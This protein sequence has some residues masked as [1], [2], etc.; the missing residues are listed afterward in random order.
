M[1]VCWDREVSHRGSCC[2]CKGPE[3]RHRRYQRQKESRLLRAQ[4]KREGDNL[5]LRVSEDQFPSW[6]L[7]HLWYQVRKWYQYITHRA[8]VI[9]V[10]KYMVL[11]KA[12]LET[13][14]LNFYFIWLKSNC[15][16]YICFLFPKNSCREFC[17]YSTCHLE[18]SFCELLTF[19][20][21]SVIRGHCREFGKYRMIIPLIL[22]I[23][24][25]SCF[26]NSLY[27]KYW[28]Y[29]FEW[30]FCPHEIMSLLRLGVDSIHISISG[31]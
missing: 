13:Y 16:M 25:F 21:T 7:S 8:N 31:A 28:N 22:Y 6:V 20:I 3:A 14:T 11:E 24:A 18:I 4:S 2:T 27:A 12:C 17:K 23:F 26:T 5:R 15:F 29:L 19:V 10:L 1:G 30:T 9:A